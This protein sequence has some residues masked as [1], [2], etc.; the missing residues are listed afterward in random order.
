MCVCVCAGEHTNPIEVDGN[1]DMALRR[2]ERRRR[3]SGGASSSSSRVV[4]IG[5]VG[6]DG[7]GGQELEVG[8]EAIGPFAGGAADRFIPTLRTAT[9]NGG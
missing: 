4:I 2:S 1:G 7:G 8:E 5:S 9:G 6:G 3:K